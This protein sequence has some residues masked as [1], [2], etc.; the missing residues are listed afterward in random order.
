MRLP[1]YVDVT[2]FTIPSC[3]FF[4]SFRFFFFSFFFLCVCTAPHFLGNSV[5]NVC[6]FRV[7]RNSVRQRVTS[8]ESFWK[9]L[10]S[11]QWCIEAEVDAHDFIRCP[12]EDGMKTRRVYCMYIHVKRLVKFETRVEPFVCEIP[13][14]A[15][16]F[17][18]FF[19]QACYRRNSE[20]F[21]SLSFCEI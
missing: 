7:W 14:Q 19:S 4:L 5:T 3:S 10:N 2:I 12:T 18:F 8:G 20:K 17:S 13:I 9:K 6:P 16:L 15:S 11:L 1:G 21:E